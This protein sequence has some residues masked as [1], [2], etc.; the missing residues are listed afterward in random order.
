M[1]ISNTHRYI[2]V[3]IPKTATHAIRFALREH[4]N[5]VSDWEHVSKY[6]TKRLP[7]EAFNGTKH[8]HLAISDLIPHLT[9]DQKTYFKFAICREPYD[10]FVSSCCFFYRKA[11]GFIRDPVA[12][13]K[14][15]ISNEQELNRVLLRPQAE[16]IADENN[17]L[18]MDYVGYFEDLN[19]SY[20]DICN[21]I[22]IPYRPLDV[23]NYNKHEPSDYYYDDELREAVYTHYRRDFELLGYLA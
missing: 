13:M 7:I 19:K 12:G 6:L 21:Q 14:Y 10:R 17:N 15:I 20:K 9:V 3:A 23:V 22:G 16:Y 18:M 5:E 1:I 2:F 8:G 4:M 11:E